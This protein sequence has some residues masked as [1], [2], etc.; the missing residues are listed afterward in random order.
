MEK[1]SKQWKKGE[2]ETE[3]KERNETLTGVICCNLLRKQSSPSQESVLGVS[4]LSLS[5]SAST[6]LIILVT[7]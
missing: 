6:G 7:A 5:E 2:S 4:Q 3:K 1:L